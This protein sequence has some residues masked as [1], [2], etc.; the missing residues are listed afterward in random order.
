[1]HGSGVMGLTPAARSDGGV[2]DAGES[3][4]G[5]RGAVWLSGI[6]HQHTNGGNAWVAATAARQS[7]AP[8]ALL[9]DPPTVRATTRR[10]VA[11]GI[12][13]SANAGT[14]WA[15]CGSTGLGSGRIV[16]WR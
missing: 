15:A 13:L 5:D 6:W 12:S 10:R 9:V 8:A 16:R 14:T 11:V 2:V 7:L 4:N 3:A 1:M